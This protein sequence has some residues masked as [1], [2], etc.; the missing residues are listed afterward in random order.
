MECTTTFE[1]FVPTVRICLRHKSSR[2]P[3]VPI[4]EFANPP[5]KPREQIA[6]DIATLPWSNNMQRYFLLI[7]DMYSRYIELV[8]MVNQE[9]VTLKAS[10]MQNWVYRHGK[11][12]VA[13][14]DQAQNIDVEVMRGMC[15]ALN[16]RKMHS[17][18]Y[19]PEGDGI[20][21]RAI[22]SVKSLLRC[23][24]EESDVSVYKWP[25]LLQQVAFVFNASISVGTGKS[26][27]EVM[28]GDTPE[29]PLTIMTNSHEKT[30]TVNTKTYCE[31]LKSKLETI[32]KDVSQEISRQKKSQAQYYNEGKKE[33]PVE[34][35]DYVYVKDNA[36]P[37]C[38]SPKYVGPYKVLWKKG[39]NVKIQLNDNK[40][41]VIHLNNCKIVKE[42]KYEQP[43]HHMM[44]DL[45]STENNNQAPL[46]SSMREEHEQE[47]ATA[48]EAAA[49]ENDD[50]QLSIAARREPRQRNQP[51]R[52]VPS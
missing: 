14:S 17:S 45:G 11:P 2:I 13:L 38:L 33:K 26:P 9:A 8:P 49:A 4:E 5:S 15:E 51:D 41:K 1:T 40:N 16:I 48:E 18:P 39:A 34:E 28:Y 23:A 27:Y 44:N 3:K 25:D 35:G 19:H 30:P 22:Q 10:L 12:K 43:L 24:L 42:S 31:E 52:Y 50:L 46:Q 21:E 47:Q 7:I 37:H 32:W 36:R 29:L 6:F 20:A